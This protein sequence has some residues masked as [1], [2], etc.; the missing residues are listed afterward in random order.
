MSKQKRPIWTKSFTSVSITNFVVFFAFYALLTTL[1]IYVINDLGG[2]QDQG[3]LIVTS[4]L[5]SAIIVRIFS[6]N[7]LAKFGQRNSLLWGTL[8]FTL[9]QFLYIWVN[10]LSS[11]LTLRF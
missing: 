9:T 2:T 6:G 10:G 7:I 1:P 3:G 8:L 4:M 11:L 5:V